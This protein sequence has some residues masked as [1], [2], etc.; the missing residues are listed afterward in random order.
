MAHR[1]PPD[2]T[3]LN[4]KLDR[5]P[6]EAW[7]WELRAYPWSSPSRGS[8]SMV[9]ICPSAGGRGVDESSC[10]GERSR[11]IM[12]KSR[13]QAAVVAQVMRP[14]CP[15]TALICFRVHRAI[16]G[17]KSSMAAESHCPAHRRA[18]REGW[19]GMVSRRWKWRPN[20]C[21]GPTEGA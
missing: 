6:D 8:Q 20:S 11:S 10:E 9:L 2:P 7:G 16:A 15:R 19:L 3:V 12:M 18:M 4:S 21:I 1:A 17:C 14:M 13:Q 5:Y